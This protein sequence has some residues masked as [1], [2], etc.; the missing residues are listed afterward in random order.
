MCGSWAKTAFQVSSL[1]GLI[2]LRTRLLLCS[3]PC[4]WG[5]LGHLCL[6]LHSQPSPRRAH[7]LHSAMEHVPPGE[8][9]QESV[10]E[11]LSA[12]WLPQPLSVTGGPAQGL[13]RLGPFR[14]SSACV[15]WGSLSPGA[16]GRRIR[17]LLPSRRLAV[18]PS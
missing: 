2:P 1:F 9:E 7:A 15:Q 13:T 5:G 4:G 14:P 18:H 17:R 8:S 11:R 10:L 12:H 16:E 6:H 3:L